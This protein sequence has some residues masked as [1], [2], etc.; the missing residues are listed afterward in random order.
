MNADAR[1]SKRAMFRANE[2]V[3]GVGAHWIGDARPAPLLPGLAALQS[4]NT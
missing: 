4:A 2:P 3:C 1:H